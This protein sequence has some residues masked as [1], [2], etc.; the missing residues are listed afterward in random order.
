MRGSGSRRPDRARR[1]TA[2]LR[3]APRGRAR[4][5]ARLAIEYFAHSTGEWSTR[6][7]RSRGRC[8]S[9]W[10]TGTSPRG[11]STLDDERLFRADRI[12]RVRADRGR[13]RAPRTRGRRTRALHAHRGRT[14]RSGC[15]WRPA[16]RWIAEYY[17]TADEQSSATD[18][19]LEV[20]LPARHAGVGGAAVAAGGEPTRRCSDPPELTARGPRPLGSRGPPS[21]DT[22]GNQSPWGSPV[23]GTETQA[24]RPAPPIARGEMTTIRTTCPRCGEVDMGPE[25]ILLSVRDD[26]R[27]G[28]YRFTCPRMRRRRGE[29]GRPQD[30]G[31]PGLGRRR[32]RAGGPASTRRRPCCSTSAD[33]E[34]RTTPVGPAFSIDDVIEFHFL[35]QDDRYIQDFFASSDGV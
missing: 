13:V 21:T 11:T 16:A 27:E 15:G 12:R 2:H 31:A 30:R 19:S 28:S 35:L 6:R 32:H 17:A 3:S 23:R 29:A 1:S 34:P 10:A 9:T 7:D 8:S 24:G 25:A 22:G 14:S 4:P 20:T 26:G 33:A 18:G 5:R